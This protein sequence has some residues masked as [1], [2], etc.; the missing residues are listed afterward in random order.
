M[1][2]KQI[3]PIKN[4]KINSEIFKLEVKLFETL[5]IMELSKRI[6]TRKV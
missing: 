5:K 3:D 2:K 6:T 1:R 4:I